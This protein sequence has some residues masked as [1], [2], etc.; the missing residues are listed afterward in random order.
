MSKFPMTL[1]GETS[2]R[3]ELERLKKVERLRIV[4]AIA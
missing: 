1:A 3:Q 4:Q 2:L